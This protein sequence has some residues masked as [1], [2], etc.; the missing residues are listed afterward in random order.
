MT[1]KS[2]YSTRND[3]KQRVQKKKRIANSFQIVQQLS[4]CFQLKVIKSMKKRLN[5]LLLSK[6]KK[7]KRSFYMQILVS[8]LAMANLVQ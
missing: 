3:S 8:K 4:G 1:W 5:H 7:K 2:V 6:K